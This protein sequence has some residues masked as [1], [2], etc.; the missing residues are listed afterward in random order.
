[1]QSSKLYTVSKVVGI[2]TQDSLI[3]NGY[4]LHAWKVFHERYPKTNQ[5][6]LSRSVKLAILFG[7]CGGSKPLTIT[8]TSISGFS[9]FRL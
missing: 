8:C 7:L 3:C 6:L 2:V 9:F 1:M 5:Y 4:Q